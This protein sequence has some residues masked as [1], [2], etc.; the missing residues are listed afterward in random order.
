MAPVLRLLQASG[1]KMSPPSGYKWYPAEAAL[2]DVT[3][4]VAR[5][6]PQYRLREDQEAFS[7]KGLMDNMISKFPH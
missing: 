2:W 3:D 7:E 5:K 6:Y 1:V 4:E